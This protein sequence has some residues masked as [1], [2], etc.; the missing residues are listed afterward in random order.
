MSGNLTRHA[1]YPSLRDLMDTVKREVK[2]EINCHAVARIESFNPEKQTVE[3]K[4]SYT[5]TYYKKDGDGNLVPYAVAYPLLLDCPAIIIGGGGG[6]LTFP[7]ANGDECLILF[8]DRD[9]DN[10][11]SGSNNSQP[12]IPTLH[13]LSD[14]IALVGLRTYKGEPEE[15][16]M[17]RAVLEYNGA[18][19]AVGKN[20]KVLVKNTATDLKA[21]IDSLVTALDT[22]A[23]ST[24]TAVIEPT[25]GPAATALKAALVTVSTNIGNILE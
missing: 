15:Y 1:P 16:D 17:E 2:I 4:I 6:S 13:S 21:A 24:S 14:G 23:T 3:A 25:L 12:E 8:N 5:K 11:V 9:L 20:G 18:I 22:F 10:W 19:V 7:I